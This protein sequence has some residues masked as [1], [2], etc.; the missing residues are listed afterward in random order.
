MWKNLWPGVPVDEIPVGP[1]TNGVHFRSSI[2]NEMNQVYDRYLGPQ[3]RENQAVLL[4]PRW[5][6]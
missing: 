6:N 4:N 5:L 1:V 2:S 3:W